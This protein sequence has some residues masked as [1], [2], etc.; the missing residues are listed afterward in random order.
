M[1][2]RNQ[3]VSISSG[4][5]KITQVANTVRVPTLNQLTI[6]FEV[7]RNTQK[8]VCHTHTHNTRT[9][10]HCYFLCNTCKASCKGFLSLHPKGQ[11][12][13]FILWILCVPEQK[14]WLFTYY[15]SSNNVALSLGTNGS[16]MTLIVDGV[17]CVINSILSPA[18]FTSQMTAFCLVWTS[19]NGKLAVYTAGVQWL[20]TCFT[21]VGHSVP[22]GGSFQLGGKIVM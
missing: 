4:N 10:V 3:K 7:Q 9:Q 19:V 21:S 11:E 6:C 18:A 2:L 20:N 14:E 8:Q 5:G 17:N 1:A 22:A 13:T 16:G 15:D 12:W